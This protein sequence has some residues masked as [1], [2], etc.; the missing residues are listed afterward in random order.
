MAARI[1][2]AARTA[3]AMGISRSVITPTAVATDTPD[4]PSAFM[5]TKAHSPRSTSQ[6]RVCSPTP[7]TESAQKPCSEGM[8]GVVSPGTV[9]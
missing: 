1:S 6:V 2:P 5:I 3:M 7:S 4:E 9:R 8:A